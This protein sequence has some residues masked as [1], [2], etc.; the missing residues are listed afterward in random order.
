MNGSVVTFQLKF[1]VR[2]YDG[3]VYAL[4]KCYTVCRRVLEL[5]QRVVKQSETILR[6]IS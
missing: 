2:L 5:P 6:L 4:I 3:M 1:Y